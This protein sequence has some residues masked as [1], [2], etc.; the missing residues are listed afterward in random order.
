MAAAANVRHPPPSR[1]R[2]V[3]VNRQL[4]IVNDDKSVIAL[5]GAAS[6]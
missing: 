1:K 2:M 6:S 4:G 5:Q 3:I